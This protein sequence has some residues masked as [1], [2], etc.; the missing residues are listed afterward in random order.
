MVEKAPIV[1]GESMGTTTYDLTCQ[2]DA[3]HTYYTEGEG[4]KAIMAEFVE[5]VN[6][7]LKSQSYP[8]VDI[9]SLLKEAVKK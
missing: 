2:R 1:F 8:T 4:Y 5:K 9:D 7:W 6:E 3:D